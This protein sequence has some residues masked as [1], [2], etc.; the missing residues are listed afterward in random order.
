VEGSTIGK[1]SWTCSCGTGNTDDHG[2]CRSCG[3]VLFDPRPS[4]PPK[5]TQWLILAGLVGLV[6]VTMYAVSHSDRK[7]TGEGATSTP[8]P[9]HAEPPSPGL[10][11]PVAEESPSKGGTP[12]DCLSLQNVDSSVVYTSPHGVYVDLSWKADIANS[13]AIPF[14]PRVV[15]EILDK[16]D[17]QLDSDELDVSVP[18]ERH[19]AS[20]KDTE[21]FR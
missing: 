18:G 12:K 7:V 11:Q 20:A 19:R 5:R 17:F 3:R 13:C 14:R 16:D 4:I 9:V 2:P 21:G 10:R 1:V 15:F 8:V 6:L